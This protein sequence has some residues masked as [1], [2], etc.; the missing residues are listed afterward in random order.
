[1]VNCGI[2]GLT[3]NNDELSIPRVPAGFGGFMKD[4]ENKFE[5]LS[6]T[7]P[8]KM[9]KT[10]TFDVSEMGNRRPEESGAPVFKVKRARS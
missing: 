2:D 7:G 5:F 8:N 3:L 10:K 1:M 9:K 6:G 4:L